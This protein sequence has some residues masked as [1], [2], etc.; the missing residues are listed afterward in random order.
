[1]KREKNDSNHDCANVFMNTMVH[2][3][4]FEYV[5]SGCLNNNTAEK[6]K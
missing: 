2:V 5:Q 1:M 3:Q 6:V 4:N